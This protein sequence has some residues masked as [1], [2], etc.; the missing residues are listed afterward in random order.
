ML[1]RKSR[2]NWRHFLLQI[3]KKILLNLLRNEKRARVEIEAQ[4][5]V[6]LLKEKKALSSSKEVIR[7]SIAARI[8]S[9]L[10]E[11]KWDELCR[12]LAGAWDTTTDSWSPFTIGEKLSL[13]T[14]IST[15]LQKKFIKNTIR[16][17]V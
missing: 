13:D 4:H 2:K 10:S 15:F 3:E 8:F 17:P 16:F 11:A 9:Q 14:Q 12:L 5:E 7:S 6:E 1:S